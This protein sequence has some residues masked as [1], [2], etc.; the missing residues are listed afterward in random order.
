MGNYHVFIIMLVFLLAAKT[1]SWCGAPLPA[2]SHMTGSL[3]Q[4]KSRW[5]R[6]CWW[7]S[8]GAAA[9]WRA[10]VW[11]SGWASSATTWEATGQLRSRMLQ[12]PFQCLLFLAFKFAKCGFGLLYCLSCGHGEIHGLFSIFNPVV[13]VQTIT[14]SNCCVR[15][16]CINKTIWTKQLITIKETKIFNQILDV[17]LVLELA[18][19]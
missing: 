8:S 12:L 15:W 17:Q 9:W 3:A 7:P 10:S 1:A 13:S 14:L 4:P 2:W 16:S 18:L 19:N 6:T 11:W 5:P